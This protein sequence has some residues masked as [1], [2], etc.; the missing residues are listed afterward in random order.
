MVSKAGIVYVTGAV[1]KPGGFVM[2]NAHMTVLQ[3]VAMAEGAVPTAA[4]DKAE[5]IR[6]AGQGTKP[7]EIPIQ[8]K[9]ILAAKAPDVNLQENDIVFVPV[10][11]AKTAGKRT[12]DAL[13]QI[14]TGAA[15]LH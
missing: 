12:V 3:A 11:G 4:L 5:V 14:A 6:N 15:V 2:E 7:E 9:K 13:V 1:T 8:L 10:S